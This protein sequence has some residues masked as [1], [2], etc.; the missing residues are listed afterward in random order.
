MINNREHRENLWQVIY[1][2][3]FSGLFP[4]SK[5]PVN[6]QIKVTLILYYEY[7]YK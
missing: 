1:I 2:L 4:F 5:M 6:T 3:C 7:F